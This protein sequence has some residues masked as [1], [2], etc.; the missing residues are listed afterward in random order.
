[1]E[2]EKLNSEKV[3]GSFM[4]ATGPID[5][6]LRNDLLFH[7][8]MQRSKAGLKGLICALKGLNPKDVKDVILLNPIDIK[9]ANLKELILDA[10]VLLNTNEILDI[11]LQLYQMKDWDRRSLLY[12]CRSFDSIGSGE[13]YQK[14]KPTTFIAIM[15]D[16]LFPDYPEFYSKYQ[17]LNIKN[18]QPYSSLLNLNVLYLNQTD[19]ATQEDI[20]NHLVY[21]AE[22]FKA[23]TWED[24]KM[25]CQVMPEFREVTEVMY[26]S[27]I[28]SQERTLYE[29]HQKYLMDKAALID[30][31][32]EDGMEAGRAESREKIEALEHSRK[33]SREEIERLQEEIKRLKEA[34]AAKA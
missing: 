21:W 29:A 20:D 11:E 13:K 14:L 23:K 12:L 5:I 16:P 15:D 34:L 28:Q 33:E 24:L 27:M 2:K 30:D 17:M 22:L 10:R 7:V 18:H 32:Y 8:V 3:T 19:L 31:A 1:M 26:H 4:D 25:L 9:A 6:S